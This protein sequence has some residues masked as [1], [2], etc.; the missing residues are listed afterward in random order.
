MHVIV[1]GAGM[2]GSWSALAL[3]RMVGQVHIYDF[4][5]VEEENVGVQAYTAEHIGMNKAQAVEMIGGG[6]PLRGHNENF[7]ESDFPL[8][9]VEA[10]IACVDSIDARSRLA[11]WTAESYTRFLIDTRVLG[12]I[13]CL[14]AVDRSDLSDYVQSLPT[15]NTLTHAPCGAKGTAYAGMWVASQVCTIVNAIGRGLPLPPKLVWHVGM[16]EKL[17]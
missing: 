8:P 11:Q 10:I 1:V 9:P 17:N 7:F 14:H 4:D 3:A 15:E 16:N 5:T 13:A 2:T 12:E 6:L